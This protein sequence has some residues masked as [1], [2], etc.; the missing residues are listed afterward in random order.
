MGLITLVE[1]AK[2]LDKGAS[3]A[4][5]EQ[6]AASSDIF[7][8]LPF[9]GLAEGAPT[10][11]GL[12]ET[13]M[14]TNLSFRGINEAAPAGSGK[15]SPFS[16]SSYIFDYDIPVDGAIIRRYGMERLNQHTMMATKAAGKLWTD[17]FFSGDNA[18]N[19][20]EFDGL[21]KRANRFAN[22]TV[23]NMGAN[24]SASAGGDALSLYSIDK[25][26]GNTSDPTHLLFSWNLMPRFIQAARDTTIAGFVIQSW[27]AIGTPKMTYNNL[28]ILWGYRKDKWGV[29]LPFNEVGAGGGGAVTTSGYVL[30]LKE[31]GLRGIQLQPLQVEG[32]KKLEDDITW[33]THLSWDVGLV[34]EAEYC[35]TR[36]SSIKDAPFV[37]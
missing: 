2:G 13:V 27:D 19:P 6:F 29:S 33:K 18:A 15:L 28:P 21:Q 5:V 20:R 23:V 1:Y 37:K 17:T 11:E 4:V 35:M 16:E 9:E 34:D 14:P 26:I 10:Y 25:A 31:G 22:R 24:A 32:P 3:R 8:A 12:R 36:I 7:E 30:S